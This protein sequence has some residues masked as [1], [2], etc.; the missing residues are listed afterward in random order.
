MTAPTL[1][2]PVTAYDHP[3][4]HWVWTKME[5]DWIA[6]RDAQWASRVAE[7]QAEVDRRNA[8]AVDYCKESRAEYLKQERVRESLQAGID[9]LQSEIEN[10]HSVMVAAA[11]EIH[12]HWQAHCDEEGY[13]PANLMLRLEKSI[14]AQYAYKAGDFERLMQE[15][16]EAVAQLDAAVRDE[17]EACAKV[18]DEQAEEGYPETCAKIIRARTKD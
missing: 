5:L 10:L 7:L 14:P 6:A 11:E 17:R 8:W 16:A 15:R 1:P 9:K 12:E 3:E 2:A 18:C 13:G 4:H